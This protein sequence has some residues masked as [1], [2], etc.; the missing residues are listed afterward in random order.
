MTKIVCVTLIGCC[1]VGQDMEFLECSL[2]PLVFVQLCLGLCREVYKEVVLEIAYFLKHNEGLESIW[3]YWVFL[4]LLL[5]FEWVKASISDAS[6]M[7][8]P[9]PDSISALVSRSYHPGFLLSP[10][11]SQKHIAF[12]V[13]KLIIFQLFGHEPLFPPSH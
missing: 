9:G 7:P 8:S 6:L 10:V 4:F 13:Q 11:T 1:W 5:L 2:G 12:P 3:Y